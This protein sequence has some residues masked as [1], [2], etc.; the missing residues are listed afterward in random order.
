MKPINKINKFIYLFY[1]QLLH[2]IPDLFCSWWFLL[3]IAN[4]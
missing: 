2:Y 1:T 3:Y 4:N